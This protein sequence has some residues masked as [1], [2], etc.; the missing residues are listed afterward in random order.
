MDASQRR[1]QRA[2]RAGQRGPSDD[3][4]LDHAR[5]GRRRKK[6]L[7]K[8][9]RPAQRRQYGLQRRPDAARTVAPGA[10]TPEWDIAET[11]GSGDVKYHMGSS[12]DREFDGVNVHFTLNANP[13]HLEVV[14]PVVIG[15]VRAKQNQRN[16]KLRN[17]VLGLLI[18]GDA[19][20]AGQGILAETFDFAELRSYKTG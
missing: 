17:K 3:R 16:D 4:R 5:L 15:R 11:G 2:S 14:N 12:S 7:G 8:I 9:L 18:H 20:F 10:R 6:I 19:A 1:R 13:S